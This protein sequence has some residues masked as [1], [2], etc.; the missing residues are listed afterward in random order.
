MLIGVL[1]V[2]PSVSPPNVIALANGLGEYLVAAIPPRAP[3][4][5][6][7]AFR[8]AQ[9]LASLARVLGPVRCPLAASDLSY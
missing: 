2:C 7:D 9:S 6:S 3:G 5:G 8:T 4:A 1:N